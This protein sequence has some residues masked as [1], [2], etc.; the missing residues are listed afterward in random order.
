MATE[1]AAT[2]TT[3]TEVPPGLVTPPSPVMPPAAIALVNVV[4]IGVPSGVFALNVIVHTPG[5]MPDPPAM[6]PPVH[7]SDDEPGALENVPP[8]QPAD[9]AKPLGFDT[10]IWLPPTSG[11][12]SVNCT[13][14][15]GPLE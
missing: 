6:V 8:E 14:V 2:I 15:T 11:R 10:T 5:L 7:E 13:P 9:V 1:A 3:L 12:L 4:P